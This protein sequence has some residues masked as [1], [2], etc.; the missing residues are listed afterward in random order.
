[1]YYHHHYHSDDQYTQQY[2]G[3]PPAPPGGPG[4]QSTIVRFHQTLSILQRSPLNDS[5]NKKLR[6]V[7]KAVFI[8]FHSLFFTEF[9]FLM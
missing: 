3:G 1:M 8:N 7:S 5:K 4:P 6:C 9:K 2:L